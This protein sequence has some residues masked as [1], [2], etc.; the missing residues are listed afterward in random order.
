MILPAN[1]S[2]I[3]EEKISHHILNSLPAVV[4]INRLDVP[5]DFLSMRNVWMNERGYELMKYSRQEIDVL[6]N[7]FFRIII[8][9]ED[10][11]IVPQSYFWHYTDTPEIF[12]VGMHR[13]QPKDCDDY[14]WLYS[15]SVVIDYFPD[16]Q[17]RESL[18][19]AM[20]ISEVMHTNNQLNYLLK[21]VARLKNQSKLS[22]LSKREKEILSLIAHGKT[23]KEIANTLFIE[24]STAK[25]HRANI[26]SKTGVRNTAE[27]VSLA[28][29]AG[30]G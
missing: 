10:L 28:I 24:L 17:P 16:G 4:Y 26:I 7:N 11:E 13:V 27:L 6:K 22:C 23:D 1:Y 12:F 30:W 14:K 2:V 15:Q 18:T 20:E 9:P 5:G 29:E 8:H 25:K 3:N 19:I 21:E